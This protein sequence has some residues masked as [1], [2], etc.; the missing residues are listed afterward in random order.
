MKCPECFI[1]FDGE[2]N[3]EYI[4]CP[5]C[6]KKINVNQAVKYYNSLKKIED[7]DRKIAEGEK[8][9]KL[10]A[11]LDECQW[12]IDN[13]DFDSALNTTDIALEL[14][15]T[16]GRVYLMRVYAKTKNF[17]DFEETSHFS[18]LKKAIEYSSIFEQENVKRIYAPYHKK[19]SVPKEELEEYVNQEADSKLKRVETLLKDGIPKHF[20]REK[21]I[22]TLTPLTIT[23]AFVFLTLLVLS[24]IFSNVYLS[25]S[26][27]VAFTVT[28]ILFAN[29]NSNVKKV[30]LFN[31]VLDVFDNIKNLNL[32]YNDKLS[33]AKS[34]EKF[35]ISFLNGDSITSIQVTIFEIM[36]ILLESEIAIDFM[37]KDK[38]FSKFI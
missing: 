33:L 20:T 28:F 7:E 3:N 9:Q 2:T 17:T 16:D 37:K 34:L 19:R 22:K 26:T 36:D 23:C 14:S 6:G 4:N 24:I 21:S 18:D 15:N 35:A 25:L 11:L 8:Y 38:T 31:S 5:S 10:N 1:E 13:E 30:K 27:A 12:L 29:L 32:H